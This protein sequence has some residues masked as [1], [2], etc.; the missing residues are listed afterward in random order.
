MNQKRESTQTVKKTLKIYYFI[1]ILFFCLTCILFTFNYFYGKYFPFV[2][3][4]I[5]HLFN[6]HFITY[7]VVG[8]IAQ[9]IDGTLGMAYGVSSTSFLL[10]NG[11]SP[12]V[13]SSS[14]HISEIFT[15]GISGFFHL[16]FKNVDKVMFW[17]LV[18][19]GVIGALLGAFFLVSFDGDF[20]RPYIS[21]Y[22]LLMGLIIIF[23]AFRKVLTFSN[24][25]RVRWLACVGGFV[26]ASGGG[27]WG[28]VVTS[29]L[30]GTGKE[31]RFTIGTV[32][33]AEFFVSIA[34]SGVFTLFIGLNNWE[35][36]TG[37]MLGGAIAAPL[38]A[39]LCSK[40][41][42]RFILIVVGLLIIFLS[43]RTLY[44]NFLVNSL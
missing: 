30:I 19:P 6:K 22:L 21:I 1:V 14:V 26:D 27:G 31:P 10:S 28:P 2:S 43:L 36:I 12:A 4:I 32:N 18:I 17:K 40:I 24:S 34:A 13:A 16:K 25:S 41:N 39:Y 7:F 3:D 38:G 44:I 9:L 35:I 42:T 5:L 37:L 23:K 15:S 33:A 8:F 29:T 20:I 11:V